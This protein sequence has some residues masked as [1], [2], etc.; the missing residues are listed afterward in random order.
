MN[1]FHS[2]LSVFIIFCLLNFG[3]VQ[4]QFF[5]NGSAIETADENCFQLTS[6]DLWLVG[7]IWNGDKINLNESFEVKVELFAGCTDLE[8]ADGL[9]F[10]LQ[11]ISTSIG[12]GGGD[13]GF[14]DVEPSLGV[15][16]DTYQNIDYEDP[17]FDHI[18]IVQDGNLRH[19]TPQGSLAGPVQA[20]ADNPNIEDCEYHP[21]RITWDAELQTLSVYLDCELRLAY[22]G[23]IVNEIFDG[24]PFVYWGFTAA[25]GGLGNV[26]E[27]CF[28]YTSF[29]DGLV[30]QTICPEGNA[31]LEATG[32]LSYQWSPAEG[33]SNPNIANPI[34]SPEE[35]TLYTVEIM[36][37]CGFPF[38]DDVL[39]TVENDPFDV[40]ING[41]SS[42]LAEVC[43]GE[44]LELSAEVP[45]PMGADYSYL[46]SSA[47]GNAISNQDSANITVVISAN[48][49]GTETI[50]VLV[51]DED[52]CTQEVDINFEIA[53]G[54]YDIPNAFTPNG[55]QINDEFGL[56]TKAAIENFTCQVFNRWG[57]LVF[58]TTSHTEFWDGTLNDKALASDVYVYLIN[59]EINDVLYE[60]NGDVTLIR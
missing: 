3:E 5:L 57:K 13:I 35:T 24:D 32:G 58:E 54:S 51:V 38:Y 7:S 22:T 23:D 18:A 26:H 1:Y 19:N 2:K 55:D 52:G 44:T 46:W 36:D 10:G 11:P 14:G 56:V 45:L 48:S 42:T 27:I 41:A 39:V 16:F 6:T 37:D 40:A 29:L 50:S 17:T 21:L 43:A 12:V 34:A 28:A 31:Q 4:A 49:I 9:V 60:E 30:D 25:T 20:S 47:L 15:E 33:L 8:G 53:E 59:F